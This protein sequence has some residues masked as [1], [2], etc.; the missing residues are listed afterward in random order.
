VLSSEERRY[1]LKQIVISAMPYTFVYA[2]V[3]LPE[4]NS[5]HVCNT[6]VLIYDMDQPIEV[7]KELYCIKDALDAEHV[8]FMVVVY[9]MM[10]SGIIDITAEVC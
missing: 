4:T 6:I 1:G 2:C 10:N 8:A 7:S 3:N 9:Y 5:V